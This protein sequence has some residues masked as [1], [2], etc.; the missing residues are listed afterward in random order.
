MQNQRNQ[1]SKP[2]ETAFG[3]SEVDANIAYDGYNANLKRHKICFFVPA[4][5]KIDAYTL[6]LPGGAL[7]EGA[8]RGRINCKTGSVII[9]A[10]GEFQGELC[11]TNIFIEGKVTSS[12]STVNGAPS[13][14]SV[15]R[16]MRQMGEDNK[17][18]GGMI[19]IGSNASVNA[20]MF[21]S[22]WRVPPDTNLQSSN[23]KNI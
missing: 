3:S 6:D 18:F 9:A 15:L 10:G 1:V 8:L 23:M 11:A 13:K 12:S 19:A 14:P 4:G 17:P 21:A 16:A 7:I 5:S 20:D 22:Q 2:A